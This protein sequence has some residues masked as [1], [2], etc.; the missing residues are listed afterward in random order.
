VW[1]VRANVQHLEGE[2]ADYGDD[3]WTSADPENPR[4]PTA[5]KQ[6]SRV[7]VPFDY[8][9]GHAQGLAE[10]TADPNPLGSLVTAPPVSLQD[11]PSNDTLATEVAQGLADFLVQPRSGG[12][13]T[14]AALVD[15]RGFRVPHH[16]VKAGRRIFN[17]VEGLTMR[18]ESITRT[19]TASTA[20]FA[21]G[22]PMVDRI[23]ARRQRRL[24]LRGQ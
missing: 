22:V 12:T 11:Q 1:G 24:E 6:Y 10:A 9:G 20:Q 15:E 2:F 21:E 4:S 16:R 23:N 19:E 3:T 8:A 13:L 18:S 17:P 5:E 14:F 7:L